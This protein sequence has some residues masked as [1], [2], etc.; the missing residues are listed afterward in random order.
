MSNLSLGTKISIALFL[1]LTIVIGLV[2][3]ATNLAGDL[4]KTAAET[5]EMSDA[6][7]GDMANLMMD[8]KNIQLAIVQVQ[9]L[10][11]DVSATR[12]QDG[13]GDGFENAEKNAKDFSRLLEE[14]DVLAK[15]LNLSEV[16]KD[17]AAMKE[18]FPAF[19]DQGQKMAKVYVAQGPAVG[20]KMMPEFDASTDKLIK[21]LETL[22]TVVDK[23]K[24]DIN[25]GLDVKTDEMVDQLKAFVKKLEIL[26]GIAFVIG[27]G[28]IA[29]VRFRVARPLQVMVAA[30]SELSRGNK[31]VVIPESSS[32]DEIGDMASA[33]GSFHSNLLAV[34]QMEKDKKEREALADAARKTQM[35]DLATSFE[36]SVG[37]IVGSFGLAVQ[38]LRSTSQKL[39]ASLDQTSQKTSI[40]ASASEETLASVQAVVAATEEL[41]AS[42]AEIGNRSG[43]ASR[44][45]AEAVHEADNT[46][47]AVEALT[48]LAQKIGDVVQFINGIASQT[49][50]L[51]L[52][53]TIEAAR[54]GEAGKGF[55]V[56]ANE[57]KSLAN[58]T[59][60]ATEEIAAQVS[61]IQNE[62]K[63]VASAIQAIVVTIQK[64]NSNAGMIAS[65]VDQQSQATQEIA[66]NMSQVSEAMREV[67]TSVTDVAR[68]T[69]ESTE[70]ASGVTRL[71]DELSVQSGTLRDQADQFVGSIRVK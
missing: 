33:L 19:Y 38:N 10:L 5:N 69:S 13:L 25:H 40:M 42:V 22:T 49:N 28:V 26:G 46:S 52:N 17:L 30:M 32:H 31:N 59:A 15:K 62:T 2:V 16:S 55:A 45:A 1:M 66:R 18:T 29:F 41:T 47:K 57:V 23:A 70:E 65:S 39:Q 56:V 21:N 51:A 20:N 14:S 48:M 60:K 63:S 35:N 61:S 54:A 67:T 50:L 4:K 8:I 11:S 6:A 44:V 71:S 27:L 9:Q 43:E 24:S 58:Q 34:E 36:K 53:A 68:N 64:I 7:M 12:A 37:S 3:E